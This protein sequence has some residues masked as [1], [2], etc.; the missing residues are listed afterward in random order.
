MNPAPTNATRPWTAMLLRHRLSALLLLG[1][2]VVIV[3][4]A[5]LWVVAGMARAMA[6][7]TAS[8]LGHSP[9]RADGLPRDAAADAGDPRRAD[10]ASD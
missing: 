9:G 1:V 2:A 3:L 7:P 10:A 8:A 5:G 4:G 6:G